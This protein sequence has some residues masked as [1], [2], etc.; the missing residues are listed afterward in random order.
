[1]S[2]YRALGLFVG[3]TP[4]TDPVALLVPV[5]VLLGPLVASLAVGER[6]ATGLKAPAVV[7]GLG[8]WLKVRWVVAGTVSA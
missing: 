4:T 2:T 6:V 8:Y 7:L 1:M 3:V 5:A